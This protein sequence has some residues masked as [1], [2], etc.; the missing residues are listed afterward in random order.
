MR[1]HK[2]SYNILGCIT[3]VL[4]VVIILAMVLPAGF[5]WFL[6]GV[7]LI[8]CGIWLCRWW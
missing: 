1:K 8:A 5:W 6:L 2:R 3:I 4:G 7:G